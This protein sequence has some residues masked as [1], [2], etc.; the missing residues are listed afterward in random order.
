MVHERSE[1]LTH[2][3]IIL[4]HNDKGC[5]WGHWCS[6]CCPFCDWFPICFQV[7]GWPWW[8]QQIHYLLLHWSDTTFGQV[9]VVVAMLQKI[10]LIMWSEIYLA[11]VKGVT[12]LLKGEK[13]PI[14]GKVW[15]NNICITFTNQ[16]LSLSESVTHLM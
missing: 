6:G 2:F 4:Y 7:C 15:I 1:Q 10:S 13:L 12:I 14:I 11:N 9:T 3:M 5:F 8:Y 16:T